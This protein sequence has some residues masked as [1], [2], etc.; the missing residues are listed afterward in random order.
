M[1]TAFRFEWV[2]QYLGH[3][4]KVIMDAGC[5]D[6]T[7]SIA[8][9]EQYPDARVIAFEGCPDNY[10]RILMQGLAEAAGVEAWHFAVCDHENG[11]DF[12][13]NSDTNQNGHFGQTGSILPFSQKLIDTW[14]SITVK[15]PRKVAS[16]RLDSFCARWGIEGIDLLH[17]DVQG[18][19]YF[20]LLGLGEMRP[21]MIYL[22]IDE[23][24][25]TGRYVGAVPEDQI[26]GWFL[27]S[28]YVE[29]WR[30]AADALYVLFS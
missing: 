6:C 11:V 10:R 25:E 23:T 17:M 27:E 15:P 8:F 1:M 5:Y 24:A 20:A 12:N 21:K 2:E 28:G 18:A 4:P 19:E 26:K 22:E 7:D 9:K 14:P 13:S 30:S 16:V 3:D 29:R